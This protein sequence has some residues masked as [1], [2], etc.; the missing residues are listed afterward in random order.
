[1]VQPV[2][3]NGAVTLEEYVQ[4]LVRTKR[5]DSLEWKVLVRIYGAAK[6][7]GFIR[8]AARDDAVL[9]RHSEAI[10]DVPITP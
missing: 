6:I 1:M 10:D 3:W 7:D 9:E 8:N 5:M 4:R 2:D